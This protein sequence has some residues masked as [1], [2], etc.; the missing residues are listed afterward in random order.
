MCMTKAYESLFC[1]AVCNSDISKSEQANDC[2]YRFLYTHYACASMTIPMEILL[3]G[4]KLS[5]LYV[6]STS[7]C[8]YNILFCH[9]SKDDLIYVE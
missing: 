7:L 6:N 3:V 5:S 4:K 9:H 1:I 8:C 2:L